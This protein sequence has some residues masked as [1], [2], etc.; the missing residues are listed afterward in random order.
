[1]VAYEGNVHSFT[2][3]LFNNP[4]GNW[5]QGTWNVLPAVLTTWANLVESSGNKTQY[6]LYKQQARDYIN[7]AEMNADLI[8]KEGAIA[9]R[10]LEYRNKID[11]GA[12]IVKVAAA[13]GNMSGSNLDVMIQKEKV[14]K[15]DE[16]TIRAN[17]ANQALTA[18]YNGYNQAANT[19]GVLSAEATKNKY[20]ALA[21]I[22]KGVQRYVT[23]SVEDSK[24]ATQNRVL[25]E[26]NEAL[27]AALLVE[28]GRDASTGQP[29]YQKEKVKMAPVGHKNTGTLFDTG[30]NTVINDASNINYGEIGG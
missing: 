23:S 18:I 21:S 5:S 12:D 30:N 10:N 16:Q 11:R 22:L 24:V 25:K 7:T 9:L 6:E 14:R 2:S 27:R 26:Q 19:Y 8:R 3:Y 29:V 4:M 28:Y 13:G 15:M 17:Y 20:S 1:M